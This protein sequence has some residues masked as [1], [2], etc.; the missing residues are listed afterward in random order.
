MTST[1]VGI[2]RMVVTAPSLFIRPEELAKAI[3]TREKGLDKEGKPIPAEELQRKIDNE[4][5][6]IKD[7]MGIELV[8][9]NGYSESNITFVADSIYYFLK[10]IASD[11]VLTQKFL[12]QKV[13]NIFF[14]TESNPDKS[15][16]EVEEALL[17]ASSKLLEEDEKLYTPLVR[18][19]RKAFVQPITYACVG[20]AMALYDAA[21][22]VE[23]AVLKGWDESAIVIA[24]DTAIY[25]SKI[26]PGAEKTQGA[27]AS[28][29]WVTKD[30]DLVEI[31]DLAES[32]HFSVPDFTKFLYEFPK[33]HGKFSEIVYV[34]FVGMAL[35]ALENS[36]RNGADSKKL[37]DAI[38]FFICH[39]PF[40]KQAI[41]FAT[42]LYSHL[43][44]RRY[45]GLFKLMQ[46]DPLIGKEP[47]G[48]YDSLIH[49][50]RMKFREFNRNGS[51]LK[52]DAE[53]VDH[54][55][56]DP[57][58]KRYWN[59]LKN[60]RSTPDSTNPRK[61]VLRPE[62]EQFLKKL[63]IDEALELP[64]RVGNSYA[65]SIFVS[66]A[67][68]LEHAYG[69]L[70]L[71][72]GYGSGAQ[73]VVYPIKVVAR[74]EIIGDKLIVHLD[75]DPRYEIDAAQYEELHSAQLKGEAYRLTSLGDLVE[76][77]KKLLRK[78]EG[79]L[80]FGFHQI[81]RNLN[82]TGEYVHSNGE[83]WT[84]VKPLFEDNE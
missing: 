4:I 65:N 21:A 28:L 32:Y 69:M 15:K 68:I 44:K 34:Y 64:K 7:G 77:D 40:P 73:G 52:H 26:A 41:Y 61:E 75:A 17:I 82:G 54:I 3:V 84:F 1:T 60:V 37:L 11:P 30:P 2:N 62:F 12:T 38:E 55:E 29:L 25:D 19:L 18:S 79:K 53:I 66:L 5:S 24:A 72:A 80:H 76:M 83:K 49:M 47:L 78:A 20:G 48:R 51:P 36:S 70:G 31:M 58:I 6:A 35:E 50:I 14:A 74:P 57:D 46:E 63:H 81:R 45:P 13:K 42:F 56:N 39:V 9:I 23:R 71:L 27:A 22:F 67:S 16:P 33:V 43:M 8:R 10:N 59:W